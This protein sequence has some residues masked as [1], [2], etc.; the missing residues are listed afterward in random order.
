MFK[1]RTTHHLEVIMENFQLYPKQILMSA[2]RELDRRYR[3]RTIN[4]Q[5]QREREAY[6]EKFGKK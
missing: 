5:R 1:Y 3:R 4:L 2:K 6:E